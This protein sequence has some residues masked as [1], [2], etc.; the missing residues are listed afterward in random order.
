MLRYGTAWCG[1]VQGS[2]ISLIIVDHFLR[3]NGSEHDL[4]AVTF[5]AIS[6]NVRKPSIDLLC[7]RTFLWA[8]DS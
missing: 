8:I 3:Q 1:V 2:G 7:T 6:G 5:L 4:D